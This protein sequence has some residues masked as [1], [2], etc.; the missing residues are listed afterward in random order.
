MRCDLDSKMN[1]AELK[2]LSLDLLQLVVIHDRRAVKEINRACKQSNFDVSY[3][4][5]FQF[6]MKGA[7]EEYCECWYLNEY[8]EYCSQRFVDTAC[9]EKLFNN[10]K[11]GYCPHVIGQSSDHI[12]VSSVS[13][14]H[15]AAASGNRDVVKYILHRNKAEKFHETESANLLP[16]VIAVINDK[17]SV[18]KCCLPTGKYE[19]E[20]WYGSLLTRNERMVLAT[21]D[22]KNGALNLVKLKCFQWN[23]FDCCFFLN[24]K[25]SNKVIRLIATYLGDITTVL[26]YVIHTRDRLAAATITEDIFQALVTL[27]INMTNVAVECVLW[28]KPEALRAVTQKAA[29]L[30]ML[31]SAGLDLEFL[32]KSLGHDECFN[33]LH[34]TCRRKS[35]YNTSKATDSEFQGG[36]R[37]IGSQAGGGYAIIQHSLHTAILQQYDKSRFVYDVSSFCSLFS[38]LSAAHSDI[39]QRD[40]M[41]MTPVHLALEIIKDK[42]SLINVLKVLFCQ[43]ADA[44]I[45]DINGRSALYLTLSSFN[46]PLGLQYHTLYLP[47]RQQNAFTPGSNLLRMMKLVLYYNAVPNYTPDAVYFAI[48]RDRNNSLLRYVEDETASVLLATNSVT[49]KKCFAQNIRQK[50][51]ALSFVAVLVELGFHVSKFASG[52]MSKLPNVVEK[53]IVDALSKPRTLESRC[54]NVIRE[55]YPGPKLQCFLDTV[56]IPEAIVNVILF[57]PYILRTEIILNSGIVRVCMEEYFCKKY[58]FFSYSHVRDK[59]CDYYMSINIKEDGFLASFKETNVKATTFWSPSHTAFHYHPP[60]VLI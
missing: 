35:D 10:V 44:N 20:R 3:E 4:I 51:L 9:L 7:W 45:K 59:I 41:G 23:S 32:A 22:R 46:S 5:S 55:T 43:G 33:I 53:Y 60:I 2:E 49:G 47:L 14:I 48:S 1:T 37:T 24:I 12:A 29:D 36:R 56:Y 31:T 21:R 57:K 30:N 38:K 58:F 16:A 39:N 34:G 11:Q 15:A 40:E 17:A 13:L 27:K 6:Y 28:N 52:L 54:R 8:F 42:Q 50:T 19:K 26:Q 25:P 18:L